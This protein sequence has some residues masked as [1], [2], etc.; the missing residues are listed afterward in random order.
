MLAA[1][2]KRASNVKLAWFLSTKVGFCCSRC[3]G[4]RRR[5]F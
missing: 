2:K 5:W 1:T 3:D 4:A